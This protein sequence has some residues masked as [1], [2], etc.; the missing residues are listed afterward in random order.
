LNNW[1][2]ATFSLLDFISFQKLISSASTFPSQ[3]RT[4]DQQSSRV[5]IIT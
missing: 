5:Q 3:L 4:A 2:L 1:F